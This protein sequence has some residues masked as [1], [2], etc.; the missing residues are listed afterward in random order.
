[1]KIKIIIDE[2]A[3]ELQ[4]YFAD[5]RFKRLALLNETG[6]PILVYERENSDKDLKLIM[7]KHK[8]VSARECY[9]SWIDKTDEEVKRWDAEHEKSNMTIRANKLKEAERLIA[10]KELDKAKQLL[11]EITS[12]EI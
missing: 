5:K 1:M 4:D 3:N 10:N 8:I 12:D 9:G 2:Q 7:S 6:K 11:E